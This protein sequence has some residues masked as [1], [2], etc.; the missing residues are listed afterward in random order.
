VRSSSARTP[1]RCG[2]CGPSIGG[3]A[4][5]KIVSPAIVR[6]RDVDGVALGVAPADVR[7]EAAAMLARVRRLVCRNDVSRVA[8]C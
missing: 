2:R 8:R 7:R 3:R 5:L 4:A 6:K 1:Y